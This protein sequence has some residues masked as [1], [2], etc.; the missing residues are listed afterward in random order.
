MNSLDT[1]FVSE[2]S[3]ALVSLILI[4]ELVD[5]FLNSQDL[6][7]YLYAWYLNSVAVKVLPLAS[8]YK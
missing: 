3:V 6:H 5:R 4:F 8:S 7:S 1:V 2:N